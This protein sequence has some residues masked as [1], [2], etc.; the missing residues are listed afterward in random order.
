MLGAKASDHQAVD[1]FLESLRK[2]GLSAQADVALAFDSDKDKTDFFSNLKSISDSSK[3]IESETKYEEDG[4]FFLFNSDSM[5][6]SK[7]A[8]DEFDDDDDSNFF[9]FTGNYGISF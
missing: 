7:P 2:F 4:E 9:F 5:P 8:Q 1:R 3:A 6:Q